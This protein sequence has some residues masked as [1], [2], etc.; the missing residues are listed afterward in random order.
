M[1]DRDSLIDRG[2]EEFRKGRFFEAHEEW[3]TLWMV[4]TGTEK[5]FLQGLIQLAAA[6]VHLG[7]G[8]V[9]PSRRLLALALAK[10]QDAP[11]GF[12]GLSFCRLKADIQA[13]ISTLENDAIPHVAGLITLVS[14]IPSPPK[15]PPSPP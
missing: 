8:R 10:I 15:N 14:A 9:E 4:S 5:R 1:G 12:A 3:E 11:E 13:A 7:R 2:I 6:L